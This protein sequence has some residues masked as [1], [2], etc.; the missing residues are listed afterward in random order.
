MQMLLQVFIDNGSIADEVKKAGGADKVLELIGTTTLEDSL[1]CANKQGIVCM[2]GMVGNKWSLPDFSTL[3]SALGHMTAS[4]DSM[5][6]VALNSWPSSLCAMETVGYII[7]QHV[8]ILFNMFQNA[9]MCSG[10]LC[11]HVTI[12]QSLQVT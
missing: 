12:P 2:T 8:F 4:V 1:K 11:L 7:Y 3:C 6:G 5:N 9:E 10:A